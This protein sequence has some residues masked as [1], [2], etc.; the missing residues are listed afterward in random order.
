MIKPSEL[1]IADV[2]RHSSL[3][4]ISFQPCAS[5]RGN[6]TVV[7][8]R[9]IRGKLF[10]ANLDKCNWPTTDEYESY[11]RDFPFKDEV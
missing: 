1:A 10:Q 5:D 8:V 3:G 9:N 4:L 7:R 6:V 2:M 11:W